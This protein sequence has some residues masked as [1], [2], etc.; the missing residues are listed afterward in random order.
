MPA[1]RILAD[2]V[3]NQ[4]AAGEVIERP[5]A[6]IKELVENSIDSGATSIE[7]TFHNG[8]KSYICVEDNGIG[9]TSDEALLALERH[10]TSK[11]REASDLNH[12]NSFGFRGEALPSI[13]SVSKFTIRTRSTEKYGTEINMN[14]GVL[15]NKRVCGMPVGTKIEVAH[16]FNSLPVRRKFLKTDAT[17][18]AHI[19]YTTR[20]FA[21]AHPHISFRLLDKR[22]TVFQSPA[23]NNLSDRIAEIWGRQMANDLVAV[24]YQDSD[25]NLILNGLTAK[26]GV[27]R[28]NRRELVTLVNRRPINSRTLG[29]AV[30]DAYHGSIQKGRY[31]P[32]FLFLSIN[33]EQ[34]DINVHPA[35]REIRFRNKDI[36]RRFVENAIR[37]SLKQTELNSGFFPPYVNDKEKPQNNASLVTLR[38]SNNGVKVPGSRSRETP[39]AINQKTKHTEPRDAI[40]SDQFATITSGS[41]TNP[42]NKNNI[43]IEDTSIAK[44]EDL[45]VGWR[46][47][48]RIKK[49]YALFES[50]QGIVMLH[51]RHAHQR[52][53]YEKIL[54]SYCSKKTDSQNLLL[55]INLEFEPLSSE[56]LRQEIELLDNYGFKIE[57]FGQNFFRLKTI[58]CWLEIKQT[59]S[60][61]RDLIEKLR[62]RTGSKISSKVHTETVA[63]LA[64]K[65]SYRAND[66]ISEN[67]IINLLSDLMKTKSPNT[68]PAGKPTISE[69]SWSDWRKRLGEE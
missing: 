38:N 13:A 24:N 19:I 53:R 3:A 36:V 34:I 9:M 44:K 58:P 12:V 26:P 48:K 11:I 59:E 7:I 47:I 33:P 65:N 68:S 25:K 2:H 6:V 42:T 5:V 61:I 55:P 39:A 10:A 40:S 1:I 27:G 51:I 30:L 45:V 52:V 67:Q 56:A 62:H 35:K 15:L 37:A 50:P 69:I 32:A 4:I 18:S 20:L 8:G 64:I 22:R 49:Y 21:V 29:F 46:F 43:D 63:K 54:E 17:E 23:C 57:E 28:S 31:P 16:L 41:T 60:F 14:K 66:P